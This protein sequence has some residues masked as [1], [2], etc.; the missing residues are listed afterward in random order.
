MKRSFAISDFF[1]G[2]FD[3]CKRNRTALIAYVLSCLVFLVIGIVVGVGISDKNVYITRNGTAV[4]LF[5]RDE[6]SA[7]VFFIKDFAVYAA[8]ALFSA[9]MFFFRFLPVLSLAP[10]LY[11]SYALGMRVTVIIFVFSASALPMLFVLFVPVCIIQICLLCVLSHKCFEFASLNGRC[12]P[13]K[14][15]IASYYK[16]LLP[17]AVILLLCSIVKIVTA[18]F[19]GSALIGVVV[20]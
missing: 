11:C 3:G 7:F 6:N 4:F 15:D 14:Y 2:I 20:Q 12:S 9:S 1:R 16:S 5:L 19:F 10:C 13:S 18:V 8:Y 17:F